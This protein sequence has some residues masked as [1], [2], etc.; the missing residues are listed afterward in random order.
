[1]VYASRAAH[2][3]AR[4]LFHSMMIYQQGLES[5]QHLM[6]RLVNVGTD[7]FA[8]SATISRAISMVA[9]NPSDQGP[10]E[11]ADLFCRQARK[12]IAKQFN[13]LFVNDDK[14]T[15]KIAQNTL[16]EKYA[17]LEEGI[18]LPD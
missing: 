18:I 4:S 9:K 5:K 17:W 15:Y 16:A 6:G 14:F 12:R 8:M 10:V 11:L 3:L 7:L 2:K 13:G 1:M